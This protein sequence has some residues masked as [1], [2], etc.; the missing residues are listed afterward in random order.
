MSRL[1]LSDRPL[2]LAS[3]SSARRKL[4]EAAGL[5]FEVVPAEIDEEAFRGAHQH[6]AASE[7][8]Q[9]LAFEKAK[10]VSRTLPDHLVLGSDQTLEHSGQIFSKSGSVENAA[11]QL[12]TLSGSSHMLWSAASVVRNSEE[13]F[14]CVSQATVTIR[15]LSDDMIA[16]YI[17]AADSSIVQS[18]GGYQMEAAG[19]HLFDRVDGDYWTILGLPMLQICQQMRRHGLLAE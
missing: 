18:V 6:L 19:L 17:E 8:A 10:A 15:S 7:L 2:V 13:I 11:L 16:T 3:Q 4:L 12:R 1:W 5:P 9:H 14:R